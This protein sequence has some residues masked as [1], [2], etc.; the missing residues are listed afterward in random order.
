MESLAVA[1]VSSLANDFVEQEKLDPDIGSTKT[2]KENFKKLTTDVAKKPVRVIFFLCF[3]I[4]IAFMVFFIQKMI[5]IFEFISTNEQLLSLI[6][7]H[8]NIERED[9]KCGVTDQSIINE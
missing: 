8:I 2:N 3:M 9:E 5:Y 6:S 1:A 4:F 7:K